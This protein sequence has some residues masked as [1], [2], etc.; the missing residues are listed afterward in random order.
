MD[1]SATV[2]RTRC[3]RAAILSA[4]MLAGICA[5]RAEEPPRVPIVPLTPPSLSVSAE[6]TVEVPPDRAQLDVGV[7]TE[8]T[9]S[10]T[11]AR[12]NARLAE[13]VLQAVRG[14]LGP[15]SDVRTVGYALSPSYEYPKEGGRPKIVG[16]VA[17]N[18]VRATIDDLSRIGPLIDAASRAGANQIQRIQFML[19]DEDGARERALREAATKARARAAALAAALNVRIVRVLSAVESAPVPRPMH[20]VMI[21]QAREAATP[22]EAGTIEIQATV[23]LTME[24]AER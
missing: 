20:D 15:K 13:A 2:I 23:S 5:A 18:T 11:A 21:A 4:A 16:Y 24:V 9:D 14:V 22:I 6:A 10:A 8:A 19:K 17:S 12:E 7:L 1:R 3:N